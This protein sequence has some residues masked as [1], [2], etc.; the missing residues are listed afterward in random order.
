MKVLVKA[1]TRAL[2][3]ANES[4]GLVLAD[5]PFNV[6]FAR[7]RWKDNLPRSEYAR[8]VRSF[9]A[10]AYR[11]AK[12][13][14]AF[15]CFCSDDPAKLHLFKASGVHV[16][17]SWQ[18]L[19]FWFR[20]NFGCPGNIIR[21]PWKP[22]V[23]PILMFGKQHRPRML[24]QKRGIN[25]LNVL[26]YPSPQSNHRRGRIHPCEKPA[27]LWSHL[28]GRT[29]GRPILDLFCGAGSSAE[30]AGKSGESWCGVDVDYFDA[31]IK[32]VATAGLFE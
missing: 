9:M 27:S 24:N 16:G 22:A 26:E 21:L 7:G 2:P 28:I 25:T 32:S 6:N 4:F 31:S 20:P 3:F 10:E 23:E 17:W 12:D 11:V 30:A 29:S 1:D 18:Q 5:P 13:G 8:F 15:Y 19:L 14:A